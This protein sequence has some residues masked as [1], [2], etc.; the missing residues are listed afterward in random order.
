MER[1]LM[2]SHGAAKILSSA[3]QEA[4]F[5]DTVRVSGYE[6]YRVMK[7]GETLYAVMIDYAL[8]IFAVG[9]PR[10]RPAATRSGSCAKAV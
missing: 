10:M 3:P 4:V 7:A 1:Y 2:C 8:A 5:L 6:R 9:G